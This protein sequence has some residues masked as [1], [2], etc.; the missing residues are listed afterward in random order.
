MATLEGNFTYTEHRRQ[1]AWRCDTTQAFA[2]TRTRAERPRAPR[3]GSAGQ[4]FAAQPYQCRLAF[5]WALKQQQQ[6]LGLGHRTHSYVAEVH[7]ATG[8]P[9]SAKE[10]EPHNLKIA[11]EGI[12]S[13]PTPST[14]DLDALVAEIQLTMQTVKPLATL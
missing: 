7:P 11:M 10:D 14:A 4:A 2:P 12:Q 6:H 13:Q 9:V 1:Q 3:G 8:Q 5:E